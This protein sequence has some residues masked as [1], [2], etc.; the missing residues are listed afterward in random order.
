LPSRQKVKYLTGQIV[1]TQN[2]SVERAAVFFEK[3][4]TNHS[5]H[6]FKPN[7]SFSI[8]AKE[9]SFAYRGKK[10][11][12]RN[13]IFVHID[14]KNGQHIVLQEKTNELKEWW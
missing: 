5:L 7:G 12:L 2:T 10:D 14:F 1:S 11:G 9:K 3:R 8:D 6:F 13:N 4:E